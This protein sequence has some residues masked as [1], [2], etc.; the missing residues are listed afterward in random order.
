M[1]NQGLSAAA[2]HNQPS[3]KTFLLLEKGANSMMTACA[4]AAA[5]AAMGES[6]SPASL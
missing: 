5:A 3:E 2:S 1:K 6:L 4:L